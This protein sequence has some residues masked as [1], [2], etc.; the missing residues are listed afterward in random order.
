MSVRGADRVAPW[1][2]DEYVLAEADGIATPEQLSVLEADPSAWRVSLQIML[3]EAEDNLKSARTLPGDERDQVVADLELEV[4]RLQAAVPRLLPERAVEPDRP[5]DRA[6][7]NGGAGPEAPRQPLAAGH[8]QLQV[9][10]EP[11]R[12]VA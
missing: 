8:T 1:Q 6:K 12:V 10:W 7:R 2:F 11:G 5:R 3:G 4:D 9:S